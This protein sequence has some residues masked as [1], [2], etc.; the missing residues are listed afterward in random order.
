MNLTVE[1]VPFER[2]SERIAHAK[3]DSNTA[4][5]QSLLY[6][7]EFLLKWVV[8][9]FVSAIK[10][11]KERSRYRIEHALV[12]AD[13]IGEWTS[14]LQK[15]FGGPTY[16][17]LDDTV[18]E[19]AKELTE[20]VGH[21]DWRYD[22]CEYINQAARILGYA[23][24][25]PVKT[26]LSVGLSLFS[27]I[28]NK[29]RGHGA[30]TTSVEDALLVPLAAAYDLLKNNL[31][32]LRA[33]CAYVRQ[34][35]SGKYRIS[36]IGG[37][38]DAFKPLTSNSG[39]QYRDGVYFSV[40]GLRRSQ[41]LSSDP[42][43]LDFYVANGSFN[44]NTYDVLS[45]ITGSVKRLDSREFHKPVDPLPGSETEGLGELIVLGEVFSNMPSD[46]NV[47]VRREEFE[48]ELMRELVAVDRHSIVTIDG[49]G[50]IGKTSSALH[51]I[52]EMAR[53]KN[54]PYECIIWFSARDVDLTI[55][56]VRSVQ[57]GGVSLD[58]FA[59]RYFKLIKGSTT[60][61]K[62]VARSFLSNAMGRDSSLKTLFV[63][64]NFETVDSPAE[65]F[66]WIDE[67]IRPPNKVLITTRIR[68]FKAD[69]PIH[70]HGMNEDECA[71]LIY[72]VANKL[73]ISSLV[74]TQLMTQFTEESAGHPYV[75]KIMMGELAKKR[76][77]RKVE[78]VMASRDE[79][80]TALFERTYSML[81]PAAQRIFL[82]ISGWRSL[83][84]EL[85]V[86]AVMIRPRNDLI[87]ARKAIDELI[88]FSFVDTVIFNSGEEFLSVPLAAQVFGRSKLK[89]S[90]FRGAITEDLAMLQQFG[91]VQKFDIGVPVEVR[92]RRLFSNIAHVLEVG[93]GRLE[94]YRP[95]IEYVARKLPQAWVYLAD[96]CRGDDML[97][98][99]YLTSYLERNGENDIVAWWRL[100]KAFERTHRAKDELNALAQ[101][102]RSKD[103]SIFDVSE[104]VNRANYI[105]SKAGST[106]NMTDRRLF[107]SELADAMRGKECDCSATDLSRLAWLHMKLH[108][109]E[110]ALTLARAGLERDPNNKHCKRLMKNLGAL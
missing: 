38:R 44:D 85:A 19:Y 28:R 63:F 66:S 104:A 56:G 89:M 25:L 90:P 72:S 40:G 57:P 22:A 37:C 70:L 50:G 24:A 36:M 65:L 106:I 93:D 62:E 71:Q 16:G 86:E 54:C 13:G 52:N 87:D 68:R 98:I 46:P 4:Y 94:S 82:T 84:S 75:I 80:L 91:V 95:V 47:Y 42:D 32:I 88:D 11:D 12:H 61:K 8:C 53:S 33:S 58:D 55:R 30:I 34:N 102:V 107:M 29:T 39:A 76:D 21:G 35:I 31:M 6:A 83:V 77:V 10:D 17:V 60:N 78:R 96:L 109:K 92:L 69:F 48:N 2:M 20:K 101:L 49:R 59:G 97:E 15:I 108:D 99:Q 67:F 26:S 43:L 41:L 73:G 103:V 14:A 3:E 64:D 110:R 1:N 45:Y 18:K 100:I 74:T 27:Y 79:V 9:V 105:M 7:S 5:L 51:V 81:T 23:E